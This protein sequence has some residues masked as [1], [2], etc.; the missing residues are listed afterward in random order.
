MTKRLIY[1]SL[2]IITLVLE[3]CPLNAEASGGCGGHFF[4]PF[5]DICWNCFFPFTIGSVPVI[6]GQHPDTANPSQPICHCGSNPLAGWGLA[7]GY[8]EPTILIDVTRHPY[9]LVNLGGIQFPKIIA[10]GEGEIDNYSSSDNHSFYYFHYYTFP[11]LSFFLKLTCEEESGFGLWMLSELD[12]TWNDEKL[13]AVLYPELGPV[14]SQI[15]ANPVALEATN[16]SDCVAAT[17]QLPL[18]SIYW[19]AGCQ[20]SLYPL[21]GAIQEHADS[22]QAST[23]LSERALLL[24]H[25]LGLVQD[26]D[27]NNLCHENYTF[28]LPKS[29]YRYQLVNPKAAKDCYPVG[30]STSTWSSGFVTVKGSEDYGY[31]LWKKRNCCARY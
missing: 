14:V 15:M 8:W 24:L 11:A 13:N 26:S 29:R 20:G 7:I 12:P 31:L 22:I 2:L 25:R 1:S 18:D 17:A 23:L 9:C 28:Y 27:K 19:N 16:T 4:N 21:E 3:L 6:N 10:V 5:S 30:H